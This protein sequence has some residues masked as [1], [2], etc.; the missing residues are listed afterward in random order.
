MASA[1]LAAGIV[2]GAMPAK[3]NAEEVTTASHVEEVQTT[4]GGIAPFAYYKFDAEENFGKDQTGRFDLTKKSNGAGIVE[5]QEENGIKYAAFRRDSENKTPDYT[6]IEQSTSG[7]SFYAKGLDKSSLD[8]SDIVA[9]S[10]TLSVTFRAPFHPDNYGACT[11][12]ALGRFNDALSIVPWQSGIEIQPY[13]RYTF[14]EVSQGEVDAKK[15]VV[16]CDRRNWVTFTVVGDYDANKVKAYVNGE[17]VDEWEVNPVSLSN[18]GVM[19][20]PQGGA[21][22][23]FSIGS[24]NSIGGGGMEAT[25]DADIKD[26]ALFDYALDDNAV[27]AVYDEEGVTYTGANYTTLPELDVSDIDMQITDANTISNILNKFSTK[28]AKVSTTNN[29]GEK[30]PLNIFWTT[31]G[32]TDTIYGIPQ[33]ET[34]ANIKGVHY[35]YK[36]DTVIKFVYD[37]N[38]V[39]L[40]EAAIKQIALNVDE[41]N[42]L[43]DDVANSIGTLSFKIEPKDGYEIVAIM[44]DDSNE[45][46]EADWER[47]DHFVMFRVRNGAKVIVE[48]RKI[49]G[50]DPVDSG[51]SG[52]SSGGSTSGKTD[53]KGCK[54]S[55]SA[56]F[57]PVALAAAAVIVSKK[58]RK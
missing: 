54:G 42:V 12:V 26:V 28:R 49:G 51:S 8:F 2:G 6:E 52:N 40:S 30:E 31:A 21:D 33:S 38:A 7:V 57:F 45:W 37:K 19:N 55:L 44:C 3:V 43:P 50:N 53:G 14:G 15:K 36:C 9:G 25:A 32:T 58:K 5:L 20:G 35:K 16:P 13:S 10:Y 47:E 56:G 24:S 11:I 18:K 39:T 27:K 46:E 34:L 17:F 1:L 41:V 4:I 48:S 22:Y 23:C 29:D